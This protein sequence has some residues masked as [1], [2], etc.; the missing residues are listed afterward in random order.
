MNKI[1]LF[2]YMIL[3][4]STFSGC[5]PMIDYDDDYYSCKDPK[6]ISYTD[7][8]EKYPAIKEPREIQKAGKIY[9][10]GDTLLINEKNKGIH[11]VDNSNKQN[12]KHIKFIEIP[13]NIDLAVKDGYLYVD[14]FIDLVVLNITD[15]NNIT[16]VHRQ[17]KVFP[18]NHLQALSEEDLKKDR[19]YPDESRGVV[20]GYK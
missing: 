1:K 9:I 19:C 16:K 2:I 10:Y 13:G 17:E 11:V 5:I 6:Y 8:R 15:I 18:Y 7:L 4:L 12:P 20:V 3:F 14:S